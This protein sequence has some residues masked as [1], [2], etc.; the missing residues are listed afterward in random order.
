M[1]KTNKSSFIEKSVKRHGDFYDYSKVVYEDSKTKVEIICPVHGSFYQT[2]QAHVRG[3]GCP[4]CAKEKRRLKLLGNKESFIKKCEKVHGKFYNYSKVNYINSSE[5]VEIICPVHGSFYQV[6]SNHL[7]GQG[8][9]KCNGRNLSTEDVVNKFKKV[10]GEFYDYSKVRFNKMHEKVEIICPE[11]GSFYQTPSKHLNGQGCPKC[12]ILKRSQ[13]N[14]IGNEEF[15]RRANKIYNGFYD[16]SEVDYTNMHEKVCIICPKHGRFYQ[17]PYDHIQGH[18]C[19]KCGIVESQA[20]NELYEYICSIVGKENVERKNRSL[21]NG[22]EIDIYVPKYNLGI[23]YNGLRWHSEEF[24]KDKNYHL[25]K[26]EAAEKS[27]VKLIQ[28]FEDEYINKKEIVLSKIKYL[29]KND[30]GLPRIMARKCSVRE[31]D[32]KMSKEFL[33]K[34]HIQGYSTSTVYIGCFFENSLVGVMSFLKRQNTWEL[35]RFATD[36]HYICQ[37]VG[38]KLFSY[39]VKNYDPEEIKSFADRRWTLNPDNNLYTKLGFKLEKTLKPDYRYVGRLY[40]NER[41]H[42]FNF[43]KKILHNKYGFSTDKTETQMVGMLD[44]YKIWDCGLFKYVWKKKYV[45]FF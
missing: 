20:E 43:R 28:I 34:N 33:E 12:A 1:I 11:H 24:G 44:C 6:P 32:N 30:F 37:G 26:T 41:I 42:K 17:R 27:G 25:A 29:L 22:K 3:D 21:L 19:P 7:N 13:E 38:G 9:P 23:E 10:H 16:Y 45:I 4:E 5:K 35:T 8:C 40:P 18:G 2:P 15:I 39:F 14:N 36:Y 31:I